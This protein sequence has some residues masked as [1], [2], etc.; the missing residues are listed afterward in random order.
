MCA[1]GRYSFLFPTDPL[2]IQALEVHGVMIPG[3]RVQRPPRTGSAVASLET[4]EAFI[5]DAPERAACPCAVH[6]SQKRHPQQEGHHLRAAQ[7]KPNPS[8]K[9]ASGASACRGS[10]VTLDVR[11]HDPPGCFNLEYNLNSEG[12]VSVFSGDAKPTPAR[13]ATTHRELQANQHLNEASVPVTEAGSHVNKE[14]LGAGRSSSP[15]QLQRITLHPL[16]VRT[17]LQLI[18]NHC[19]L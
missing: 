14:G 8:S 13:C 6:M 19:M 11:V 16:C 5:I 4:N 18:S 3:H 15:W 17:L 9:T 1:Y 2:S 10:E 7:E 12:F